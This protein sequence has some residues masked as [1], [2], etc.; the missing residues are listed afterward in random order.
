[1]PLDIVQHEV[2]LWNA[3]VKQGMFHVRYPTS[4]TT[5]NVLVLQLPFAIA[6][7]CTSVDVVVDLVPLFPREFITVHRVRLAHCSRA[8]T[9][10][11]ERDTA[12]MLDCMHTQWALRCTNQLCRAAGHARDILAP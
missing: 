12:S 3:F 11:R 8:C 10:F 1:M 9:N 7:R 5:M 6:V 2:R 4:T